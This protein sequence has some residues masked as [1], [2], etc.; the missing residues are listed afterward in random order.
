MLVSL[1]VV[2]LIGFL[3]DNRLQSLLS[4]QLGEKLLTAAKTGALMVNGDLHAQLHTREDE[5]TWTYNN[6]KQVFRQ[7]K[8]AN[9][10]TYVYSMILDGGKVSFVVDAADGEDMSHIGDTYD[11]LEPEMKAAFEG[12]PGYTKGSYTD[13]WG[14][15]KTAYGVIRNS[16]GKVVA[17]L[18]WTLRQPASW[19]PSIAFA[20]NSWRSWRAAFCWRG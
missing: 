2:A 5:N 15:F 20:C 8:E 4:D 17:I 19:P 11:R 3:I 9:N 6:L 7:I 14:T 13:D 18:G 10:L 16:A 1:V 12:R